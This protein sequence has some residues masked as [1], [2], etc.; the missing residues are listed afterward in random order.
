[1]TGLS[2]VGLSTVVQDLSTGA[3]IVIAAS[4]SQIVRGHDVWLA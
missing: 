4:L 2:I 3:R 1:M